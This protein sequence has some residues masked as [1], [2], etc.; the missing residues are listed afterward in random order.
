MLSYINDK[1]AYFVMKK[2]KYLLLASALVLVGCQPSQAENTNEQAEGQTS[3]EAQVEQTDANTGDEANQDEQ[4]T[5]EEGQA[6]AERPEHLPNPWTDYSQY[7]EPNEAGFAYEIESDPDI[8]SEIR[9]LNDK[10]AGNVVLFT[11]DDAPQGGGDS[12]ALTMAQLMK[13]KDVNAIFLVNGFRIDEAGAEIIKQVHD[14]GFEIGNH[15]E[16]HTD[17]R[18]LTYEEQYEEISATNEKIEAITGQPARWFRPPFGSFNMDTIKICNELGLQLMNWT[19]G[20]DWME[21]YQDGAALTEIS[22]TT[23]Y[24]HDG[25]NILMHDLP[26]TLDALDE[27]IDGLREQGYHIVDPLLIQDQRNSEEPIPAE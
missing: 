8:S 6:F 9:P 5:A 15:T 26:W 12:D 14:M 3:Q 13:E 18:T 1:E 24:L 7:A 17:L 10:S 11:F 23:E 25:A 4:A 21:E 22:L 2:F 16:T 20:Y 27:M 19:F